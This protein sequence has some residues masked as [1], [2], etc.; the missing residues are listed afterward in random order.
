MTDPQDKASYY[1]GVGASFTTGFLVCLL[2]IYFII[3]MNKTIYSAS[4]SFVCGNPDTIVVV[5]T[6]LVD[7]SEPAYLKKYSN[8]RIPT[9]YR[10]LELNN[11]DFVPQKKSEYSWE[12]WQNLMCHNPDQSSTD[13]LFLNDP[14]RGRKF[15]YRSEAIKLIHDYIEYSKQFQVKNEY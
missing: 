4:K 13:C 2:A 14:K 9:G 8:W 7:I 6:V 15:K 1:L 12:G 5:D 10:V 3:P 11:G